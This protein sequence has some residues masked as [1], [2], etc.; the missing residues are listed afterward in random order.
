MQGK[1][2]ITQI[3]LLSTTATVSILYL[4]DAEHQLLPCTW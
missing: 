1:E 4:F 3:N 2:L